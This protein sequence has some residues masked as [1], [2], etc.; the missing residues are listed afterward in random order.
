MIKVMLMHLLLHFT[1]VKTLRWAS[2]LSPGVKQ[3]EGKLWWSTNKGFTMCA[4]SSDTDKFLL[5]KTDT[6]NQL[7]IYV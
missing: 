1:E 7:H 5:F 2:E 4:F 6:N 3:T